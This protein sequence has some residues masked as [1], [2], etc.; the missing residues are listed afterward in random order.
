M[1]IPN[2]PA[3]LELAQQQMPNWH[4]EASDTS[5]FLARDTIMATG[6]SKAMPPWREKLFAFLARNA[7]HGAEYYSLPANRLVEMGGQIN[8]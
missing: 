7:A 4:Y 8:L 2:V 5:F 1:E 3:I 6:A